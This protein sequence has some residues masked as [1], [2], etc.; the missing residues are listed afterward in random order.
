[1]NTMDESRNG[2]GIEDEYQSVRKEAGGSDSA[3]I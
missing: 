2:Q 3:K 1:M